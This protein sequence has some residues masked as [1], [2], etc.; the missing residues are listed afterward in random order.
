M[1]INV[2]GSYRSY[3]SQMR[4]QSLFQPAS[5][6][7]FFY[8][9][10]PF[11]LATLIQSQH[12][13]KQQIFSIYISLFR[14]LILLFRFVKQFDSFLKRRKRAIKEKRTYLLPLPLLSYFSKLCFSFSS[15]MYNY[16]HFDTLNFIMLLLL[17]FNCWR[18]SI[19]DI[20]IPLISKK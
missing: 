4:F 9:L 8:I 3:E 19:T 10:K 5:I 11:C 15:Y 17:S 16:Q 6:N 7:L 18:L 20:F 2:A 14:L 12:F 1:L 13:S